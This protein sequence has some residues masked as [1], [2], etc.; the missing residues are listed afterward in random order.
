MYICYKILYFVRKTR[1]YSGDNFR[2][3]KG[4]KVLVLSRDILKRPMTEG[5]IHE[6]TIEYSMPQIKPN[7]P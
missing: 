3:K 1:G 7:E 6:L 2:G 4:K 5:M